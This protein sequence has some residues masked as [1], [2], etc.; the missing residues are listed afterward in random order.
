MGKC[1][2]NPPA[3]PSWKVPANSNGQLLSVS[4]QVSVPIAMTTE[5]GGGELFRYF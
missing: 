4:G 5:A 2:F 3:V 1:W